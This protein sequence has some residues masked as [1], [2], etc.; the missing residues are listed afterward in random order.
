MRPANLRASPGNPGEI[1]SGLRTP[2]RGHCIHRSGLPSPQMIPVSLLLVW[3]PAAHVSPWH[4]H[5]RALHPD[6]HVL[7]LTGVPTI[8][9]RPVQVLVSVQGQQRGKSVA[10]AEGTLG[11]R[12]AV[13]SSSSPPNPCS[14]FIPYIKPTPPESASPIVA[15]PPWSPLPP[16]PVP[17]PELTLKMYP[18]HTY[19][20]TECISTSHMQYMTYISIIHV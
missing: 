15:A 4:A 6:E 16:S 11:L 10:P 13:T 5:E 19:N 20:S 1:P 2:T 7:A 14:Q 17:Q 9:E 3:R 18:R 12:H 8:C